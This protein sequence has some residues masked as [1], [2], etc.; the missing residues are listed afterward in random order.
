MAT[1][2]YASPIILDCG[3]ARNGTCARGRCHNGSGFNHSARRKR[4]QGLSD[5]LIDLIYCTQ[6]G[7][8]GHRR[9]RH[10]TSSPAKARRDENSAKPTVF[11]RSF[12]QH[13]SQSSPTRAGAT[14]VVFQ[15]S[16]AAAV[17]KTT[18]ALSRAK[19]V[20]CADCDSSCRVG[21]LCTNR[22]V[23]KNASRCEV[24]RAED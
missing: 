2:S 7:I 10:S 19:I 16:F 4:Q 13:D 9:K 11:H 17:T 15:R 6:Y 1:G 3:E 23:T 24:L 12:V 22:P 20:R 5:C 14:N 21:S 8:E 18:A